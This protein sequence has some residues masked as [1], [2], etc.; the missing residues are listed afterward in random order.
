MLE[1]KRIGVVVPAYID[2]T[3]KAH[4]KGTRFIKPVKVT[5][6]YGKPITQDDFQ[7]LGKGRDAYDQHAALI[8]QRIADLKAEAKR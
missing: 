6:T 5:I 8:M 7:A 1:D 2:G 3:Y 4:P